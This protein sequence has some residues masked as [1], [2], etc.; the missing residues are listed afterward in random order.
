MHDNQ[1]K[2]RAFLRGAV[3]LPFFGGLLLGQR[4]QA[5]QSGRI[6]RQKSPEN[7]ESPFAALDSYLTPTDRFF[8]R[9][10]FA[11]PKIDPRAWRLKVEGAVERPLELTLEGLRQLPART[12]PAVLECAGNG[13][14]FLV[15]G[16][17]GLQWEMGAVG[18]ADW[19]GVPLAA[20]LEKAGVRAGAVEVVLEGADQ[21]E[22]RDDP[23][24]AGVIPFARSLTLAKARQP[25][26]L[27]AH[28]MNGADLSPSHGFPVRCIVPGWYGMASVK[29]LTRII[30]VDRPF[31]GFFQSINYT[32]WERRD[33]GAVLAPVTEVQV[34]AQIAR[35]TVHEVIRP[36]TAYRMHGAAWTG[37]SE[38]T[39]VEVSAD[40]GKTWGEAKLLD[41][42]IKY[43]WRRWEYEW[44]TPGKP[45]AITLMARA[46]DAR[47]RSQPAQRDPDRREYMISHTLPVDVE[48]R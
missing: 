42:P 5:Q 28:Q 27:L 31:L 43:A 26:V 9:S 34:K 48:V 20:I 15:P 25:E 22:I 46:T 29:W 39:K 19:S 8:V 6:I 10:H 2:R 45:G 41:K 23:K 21:G 47:G 17:R 7:L 38:V 40:A 37:D 4:G 3:A 33:S 1:M 12:Q 35:P 30:V 36:G 16:V 18:N 32:Y 13:R 14:L 11:V 24:S 44:R